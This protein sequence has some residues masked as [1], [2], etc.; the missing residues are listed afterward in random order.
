MIVLA[1]LTVA[2]IVVIIYFNRKWEKEYTA[3]DADALKRLH[4]SNWTPVNYYDAFVA[5]KSRS[6]CEKYDE[7]KYFK[8]NPEMLSTMESIIAEKQSITDA[9]T[10]FWKENEYQSHPLYS[11][12]RKKTDHS[13]KQCK[14]MSNLSEIHLSQRDFHRDKRN[15]SHPTGH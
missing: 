3:M 14:G 9:A 5:V 1:I 10:A 13:F 7:V 15:S 2:L 11:R 8:E 4:L 6:S 12:L